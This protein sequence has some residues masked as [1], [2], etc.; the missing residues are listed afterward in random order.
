MSH[1]ER[2]YGMVY[3]PL[4]IAPSTPP[5]VRVLIQRIEDLSFSD[6]HSMLRLPLHHYRLSAGCNFA[7]THVLMAVIGGVSTTL[8]RHTGNV[9]DRFTGVLVNYFPWNKE[10]TS[11]VSP[12]DAAD[13]IY[14][15]FR[16]PITHDLGLDLKK[17][18]AGGKGKSKTAQDCNYT[19]RGQGSH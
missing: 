18:S 2:V 17:K 8:Y 14:S 3:Q 5:R 15:V 6:T 4:N 1:R 9:G 11:N 19:G 12:V 7:I 10:P 16:N 13:A